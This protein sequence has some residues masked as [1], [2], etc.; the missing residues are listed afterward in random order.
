MVTV[1]APV[2]WRYSSRS[3]GA[4]SSP[5]PRS[6]RSRD[7]RSA[8]SV[9]PASTSTASCARARPRRSWPRARRRRRSRAIVTSL[10]EG[11]AG[12]VMVTR[13]DEPVA[14]PRS[15]TSPPT[16]ASTRRAR[17]GWVAQVGARAARP[18]HDRLGRH[19]GR[20]GR[21]RG[22]GSAPSCS[23]RTV[24][25]HEDAGVAGLHRL[26]PALPD[27][28]RADCVIVVAGQ[29][30]ALASVV[31]GL[32]AA[33][34]IG[35]PDEHAATGAA[36]GGVTALLA[37]LTSC[38]A[39]VAVVNIDDGFGAGTIAARIARAAARRPPPAH[40]VQPVPTP[41]RPAPVTACSTST[42]SGVAGDMLLAAL[43]DAG[44]DAAV[45]ARRCSARPRRRRPRAAQRAR[46]AATGSPRTHVSVV[47]PRE[48]EPR[49]HATAPRA[50]IRRLL[51]A[52]PLPERARERARR[53]C[54]RRSSPAEGT[55]PRRRR[56]T[57][58]TS[59]RSARSTRSATSPGSRSRSSR[60][61]STRLACSPLPARARPVRHRPRA[62]A[63]AR[64][65][66]ARAAARRAALR[67][68]PRRRAGDADRR[69]GRRRRSP[70]TSG[71]CRAMRLERGRL[72][73]RHARPRRAPERHP[74]ARSAARAP[75]AGEPT[76]PR[77]GGADR[78]QPRRPLSRAR[79]RRRRALLRRRRARRLGGARADEEG[80]P[81]DRAS[82]R[83]RAPADERAVAHAIL[84]ETT[85][86]RRARLA[87]PPLGARAR[88]RSRSRS[89]GE[90]V[91]RQ[92]RAARRAS[93]QRSRPST[94][95]ASPPRGAIGR[96]VKDVWAAA[97]AAARGSPCD[98]VRARTVAR[99]PTASSTAADRARCVLE[100]RIA[101]SARLSAGGVDSSLVAA[102]AAARPRRSRARRH[103]RLRRAR[104]RRA[105]RRRGVAAAVGI[106]HRR[107]P[108]TSSTRPDYRRN[109][110]FRCFHCKTELYGRL[111]GARARARL[112]P[113]SSPA[114]TPT[115]PAIG[116]PA[117]ARPP[118]T[119]CIHPLLEA[120]RRQADGARARASLGVP[121]AGEA[122]DA[123]PGLADPL[124]DA[125]RR[126]PRSRGS[127]RR[128]GRPR[129][130]ASAS[131]AC[132][133]TV[134]S[135][136]SSSAPR[137]SIAPW[138]TATRCWM[139]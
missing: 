91:A 58:S 122:G 120:R 138:R 29:D 27:L 4:R 72:R 59:T 49:G 74:R 82:R 105:R 86:A 117:C 38:A 136:A 1:C 36:F 68:R 5:R 85:R 40:R 121:S 124:R 96:P 65:G 18:R 44:A 62:A 32:V 102:L 26:A 112:S 73:R 83:S 101:T 19:L 126:R 115:T 43:L 111:A 11:G 125:G 15:A 28:R 66:D 24:T 67:R 12:S 41:A 92:A 6:R 23:A 22:A 76:G 133:T 52:A 55:R 100:T 87:R 16:R 42:P 135:A 90:P 61:A 114:P 30:A 64:P 104:R 63:A 79:A 10:L 134:R 71:R 3:A 127:T 48:S 132:A 25:V 8:T 50:E 20:P 94:T 9:S 88:A 37:M 57:R 123:V 56:R 108:P 107:S 80:P 35:V 78:D 77:R 113:P 31:G 33:P 116:A 119:A 54:S 139:P 13:A 98:D 45:V 95:T 39:G 118:S 106:A 84:R 137:S 21:A 47:A 99:T 129:R 128:A 60:S 69:R 93:R 53:R 109:D 131:S 46:R 2:C 81:R 51:D 34:V 110:R 75:R 17:V 97:L 14:A 130:S 7:W 70:T 89:D 103:R